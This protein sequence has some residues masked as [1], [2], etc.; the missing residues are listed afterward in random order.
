VR[1]GKRITDNGKLRNRLSI[2]R[3][4]FSVVL[5][6]QPNQRQQQN[7]AEQNERA[8]NLITRKSHSLFRHFHRARAVA[9]A[10]VLTYFSD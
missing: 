10:N 7:R 8:D 1:N 3:Y 5:N 9:S 2:F 6:Y 4:P